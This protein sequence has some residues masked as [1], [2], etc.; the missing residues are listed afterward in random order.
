MDEMENLENENPVIIQDDDLYNKK[1]VA[2]PAPERKKDIDV[3]NTFYENIIDGVINNVLDLNSFNKISEIRR[4]WT[5][6][7][8]LSDLIVCVGTDDISTVFVSTGASVTTCFGAIIE[9]TIHH[10]AINT[11]NHH[12]KPEKP[13]FLAVAFL[14]A[15]H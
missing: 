13:P 11:N 6:A 5:F 1:T 9:P 8:I 4:P 12:K 15:F 2:V 3:E 7:E 14:L 10:A